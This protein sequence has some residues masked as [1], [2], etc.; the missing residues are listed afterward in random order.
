V[1]DAHFLHS[2]WFRRQFAQIIRGQTQ[3]N[4]M[5]CIHSFKTAAFIRCPNSKTPGAVCLTHLRFVH[6]HLFK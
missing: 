5:A 6:Q 2:Y 4:W 1:I 3:Q